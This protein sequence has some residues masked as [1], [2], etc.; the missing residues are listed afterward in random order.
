M[1]KPRRRNKLDPPEGSGGIL[2][3]PD[4]QAKG[5][6]TR[7]KPRRRPPGNNDDD[8]RSVESEEQPNR[9]RRRPRNTATDSDASG[10]LSTSSSRDDPKPSASCSVSAATAT[11]RHHHHHH[12]HSRSGGG[13]GGK[14]DA[15]VSSSRSAKRTIKRAPS[16]TSKPLKKQLSARSKLDDTSSG[17]ITAEESSLRW[18]DE[19]VVVVESTD[20]ASSGSAHHAAFDFAA[21]GFAGSQHDD[22]GFGSLPKIPNDDSDAGFSNF[23]ALA[24]LG[25]VT[26]DTGFGGGSK[27]LNKSDFDSAFSTDAFDTGKAFDGFGQKSVSNF[28]IDFN[29]FLGKDD[30]DIG[31][32]R[33]S[34]VQESPPKKIWDK[35]P[36]PPDLP[37]RTM[38]KPVLSQLQTRV[39]L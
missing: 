6:K 27:S 23:D 11:R 17:Q 29:A 16:T 13:G 30:H 10:D 31:F 33:L 9:T 22:G 20:T 32:G 36:L 28:Q 26:A 21:F 5:G 38:Q 7:R 4:L 15:S 2:M 19:K 14:D 24:P 8:E 39:G 18:E 3:S 35:S 37:T 12:Q 34:V 25:A 1:E